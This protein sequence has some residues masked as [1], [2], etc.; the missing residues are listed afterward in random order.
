[1]I[2]TFTCLLFL[3]LSDYF[4]YWVHHMPW[5]IHRFRRTSNC[6][7]L[8]SFQMFTGHL[9][10]IKLHLLTIVLLGPNQ[11]KQTAATPRTY[12]IGQAHLIAVIHINFALFN[13]RLQLPPFMPRLYPA[14]N[15]SRYKWYN[16]ED[17]NVTV[18]G[19]LRGI[20]VLI[21]LMKHANI[22]IFSIISWH[23]DQS[24]ILSI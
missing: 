17:T 5:N 8:P 9:F 16:I 23:W 21:V 7:T 22:L 15:M 19:L 3:P 24:I 20:Y 12:F 1:M 10:H 2:W 14:I 11:P 6:W 4:V 13:P 18:D